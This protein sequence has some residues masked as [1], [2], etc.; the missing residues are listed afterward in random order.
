MNR[1]TVMQALGLDPSRPAAILHADDVGMCHGANVAY[2]ELARAGALNCGSIMVPCPW[3]AEIAVEAASDDSLDLGVHLTLTSEWPS[4]RWGPLTRADRSSGL[5]DGMG[6][7]HRTIAALVENVVPEAAEVEM[8]A[9]IDRA[10]DVG[11]DVTHLDTHMGAALA[12]PLLE[13]TLRVSRDYDLPILLPR[14]GAVYRQ[15]LKLAHHEGEAQWTEAVQ[16]AEAL[17]EPLVDHFSMT[18]GAPI[19][20]AATAYRKLVDDLE[21]GITFVALH[22]NA[23]GDIETIVPPRAHWRVEETEVLRN[24]SMVGWLGERGIQTIGMRP[25]RDLLRRKKSC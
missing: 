6:Y 10:L 18:P 14:H 17:D 15:V 16:K 3:F 12:P 5:V 7:F 9:Q 21:P 23:S 2:L 4:Y 22:P 24:G 1:S 25:F 8:R 19:G 20:G 11:I 13:T